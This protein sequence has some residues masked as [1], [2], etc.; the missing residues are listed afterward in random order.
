MVLAAADNFNTL[1]VV[2]FFVGD[3]H[4]IKLDTRIFSNA[5]LQVSRSRPSILLYST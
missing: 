4:G 1:V 2:R 3:C 5:F